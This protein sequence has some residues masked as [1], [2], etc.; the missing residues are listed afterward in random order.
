MAQTEAATKHVGTAG[1]DYMLLI[2][3]IWACLTSAFL[4]HTYVS[5]R[6]RE[7]VP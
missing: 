5:V 4:L 7:R 2:V 3:V 6:I 1:Y